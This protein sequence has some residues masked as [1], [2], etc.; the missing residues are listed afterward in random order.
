LPIFATAGPP[1]FPPVRVLELHLHDF[2]NY[3]AAS[4]RFGEGFTCIT[5][6]N[7]V[8]KT[9][10]LEAVHY[11][12]FCRG[13][14]PGPDALSVRHDAPGF[15]V[16]TRFANAGRVWDVAV[17]YR[18]RGGKQLSVNG[19]AVPRLADHIGRLPTVFLG[20]EDQ[21]LVDGYAEER[22]RLMDASIAQVD[23][24]YLE[25][26]MRYNRALGQRNAV[27]KAA[28]EGRGFDQAL[29]DSFDPVLAG[30][31]ETIRAAREGW[32]A[33]IG[34]VFADV[35]A[36]LSG[37]RERPGLEWRA[38]WT[39]RGGLVAAFRAVQRQ[40]EVLGRCTAGPHRDDLDLT[41]D[42]H[43]A[44]RLGSQG[45]KKTLLLALRLAQGAWLETRLGHPPLLLLDDVFDKLDRERARALFALLGEGEG[46]QV[47][48]TDTNANR[49]ETLFAELGLAHRHV[50]VDAGPEGPLLHGGDAP[51]AP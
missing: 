5:G 9:N 14:R 3:P 35:Y 26:L 4:L 41:L 29:L 34:P 46:R 43:P 18:H 32:V 48:L 25:A 11:G 28:R 19:E 33:E 44:K 36:R 21:A 6:A 47:L 7:G 50:R 22:R 13:V 20:P 16:A 24:P 39:E 1:R 10:L 51:A 8:G 49:V 17:V 45:Q 12:A 42:G 37:R 38:E 31:A 15:R 23:R 40:D 2:R 27:L 30:A